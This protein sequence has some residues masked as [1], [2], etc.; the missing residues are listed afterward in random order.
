MYQ[1]WS[2]MKQLRLSLSSPSKWANSNK[3]CDSENAMIEVEST[4]E[5]GM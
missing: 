3:I 1:K 4:D 5:I 2:N